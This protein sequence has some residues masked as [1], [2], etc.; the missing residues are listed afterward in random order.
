MAEKKES[1]R[2]RK[3]RDPSKLLDEY[4]L[5]MAKLTLR[6]ARAAINLRKKRG[7]A[8]YIV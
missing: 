8:P 1:K 5:K 6:M 7:E 4:E 2:L 3:R